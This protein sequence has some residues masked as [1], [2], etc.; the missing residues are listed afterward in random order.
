MMGA[1][2]PTDQR[3]HVCRGTGTGQEDEATRQAFAA[4]YVFAEQIA[5][6]GNDGFGG[7]DRDV[8]RRQQASHACLLI[9]NV[10]ADGPRACHSRKSFSHASRRIDHLF[11]SRVSADSRIAHEFCKEFGGKILRRSEQYAARVS[12]GSQDSVTQ[13]RRGT[14]D[15]VDSRD[16]GRGGRHEAIQID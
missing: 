13:G 11:R 1:V 8:Q 4:E 9:A 14:V 10:D 2:D 16:S 6:L 5:G 7:D 12:S 15:D 3:A